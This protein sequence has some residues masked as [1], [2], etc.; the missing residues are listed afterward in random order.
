[1]F[2][3]HL[4][5]YRHYVRQWPALPRLLFPLNFVCEA[6]FVPHMSR[7]GHIRSYLVLSS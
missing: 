7:Q 2:F 1:M 5:W 6:V 3:D 4:T